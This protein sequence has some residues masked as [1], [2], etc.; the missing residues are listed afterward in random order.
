MSDIIREI[1]TVSAGSISSDATGNSGSTISVNVEDFTIDER[2]ITTSG[3]VTLTSSLTVDTTGTVNKDRSLVFRL[4][5]DINLNGNTFTVLGTTIPQE[6]LNKHSYIIARYDGSNWQVQYRPDFEETK[7]IQ[8][9]HLIDDAVNKD[10]LDVSNISGKGLKE[11]SGG[12]IEVQPDTTNETSIESSS[13]GVRLSGDKASPANFKFYGVESSTKGF[14]TLSG[15]ITNYDSGWVDFPKYQNTSKGFY[16]LTNFD[17]PQ[18][19]IIGRVLYMRGSILIPLDSGGLVTD[20]SNYTSTQSTDVNTSSTGISFPNGGIA[21]GEIIKFPELF[22]STKFRPKKTVFSNDVV[23]GKR[24][25]QE[26]NSTVIM[27]L[28]TVAMTFK[29]NTDGT[30]EIFG[31]HNFE[32]P[33]ASAGNSSTHFENM[34]LRY[35]ITKGTKDNYALDWSNFEHSHD[36]NNF[37]N[38]HEKSSYQFGVSIDASDVQQWGGFIFPLERF[39][40]LL[41]DTISLDSIKADFP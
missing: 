34:P 13:D 33:S 9:D 39:S 14:Y 38:D 37:L 35:F 8:T 41:D 7:F 2:L 4:E 12:E 30:L 26:K 10:K 21:S 22:P 24:R 6:H 16:D 40:F 18:Y 20:A 32:I 5:A 23:I 19:R 15:A 25:L 3:S 31:V 36:G 27:S 17:H 1:L 11:A 29:F 28:S